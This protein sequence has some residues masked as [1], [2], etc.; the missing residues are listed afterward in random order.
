[1]LTIQFES[2][3]FT[4]QELKEYLEQQGLL[5][6]IEAS[7]VPA[8]K[9]G[10]SNLQDLLEFLMG[11]EFAS[12]ILKE[13]LKEMVKFAFKKA[14]DIAFSKPHILVRFSN[15]M[16]KKILYEGKGE[17]TIVQELMDCFDNNDVV[18]VIFK[19]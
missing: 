2:E 17:S 7:I 6:E 12:E 10:L 4:A 18:R 3:D 16:E 13:V 19:S 8:K 1:M 9:E 14:S 15:N 11:N 5:Q